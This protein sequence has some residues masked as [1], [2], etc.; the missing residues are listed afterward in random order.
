VTAALA[1][2][3]GPMSRAP[4]MAREVAMKPDLRNILILIF[5]PSS[6]LKID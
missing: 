6:S 3:T 2:E 1:V 4:I 5:T